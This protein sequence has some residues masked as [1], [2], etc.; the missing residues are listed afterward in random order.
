MSEDWYDEYEAEDGTD[1]GIRT[2]V[3][4]VD[5]RPPALELARA[6]RGLSVIIPPRRSRLSK[7]RIPVEWGMPEV[8]LAFVKKT[9]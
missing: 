9:H 7:R 1:P 2:I 5:T 4:Y 6:K 3:G 8:S